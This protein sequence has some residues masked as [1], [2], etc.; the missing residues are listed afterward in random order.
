MLLRFLERVTDAQKLD[1]V[2]LALVETMDHYGFDRL[3][4]GYTRSRLGK[5][6]GERADNLMLSNHP[7]EYL[8][9]FIESGLYQQA[10]MVKWA[11]ENVGACSWSWLR[12][13]ADHLTEAERRIIALNRK[14][15]ITAGYSVSFKDISIRAKG[16]IGLVARPGLDQD[17]VDAIW[18]RHGR[19]IV[20]MCN[21]AH[22]KI[23]GL[24]HPTQRRPLT[25]R[26]REVLEWVGE[27]KT[28]QDIATIMGVSKATVEKHLRLAREALDVETSA[29]AVLKASIHNQIYLLGS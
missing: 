22:L 17:D 12:D 5:S 19:I 9:L 25:A 6:F 29:Q 13:N 21:V 10:P 28:T 11:A 8:R 18:R 7:P 27:G 1:Q 16:A 2:W 15:G 26:Q 20:Q 4:Y 24:P 23:T 14:Y 3:L